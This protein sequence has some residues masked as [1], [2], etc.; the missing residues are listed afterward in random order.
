MTETTHAEL[1]R[2]YTEICD[3]LC[4]WPYVT[5]DQEE[6]N[7]RCAKCQTLID[8]ANL[9]EK[10]EAKQI[11]QPLVKEGPRTRK[12]PRCGALYGLSSSRVKGDTEYCSYCGQLTSGWMEVSEHRKKP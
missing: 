11:A 6:M 2:I 7:D 9:V 5:G 3:K 4:H 10:L 1:D 8:L 12:C